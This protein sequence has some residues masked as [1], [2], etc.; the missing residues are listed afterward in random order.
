MNVPRADSAALP[1]SGAIAR[2]QGLLTLL[3]NRLVPP[4]FITVILITAH[5]S[6]GIL[7]GYTRTALAIA[8]AIAAELLMARLTYGRWPHPASRRW[9]CFASTART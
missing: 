8:A 4:I 6:F 3:G 1:S 7:E 2:S 5:L 9:R